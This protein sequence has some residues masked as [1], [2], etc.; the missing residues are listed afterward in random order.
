MKAFL[1]HLGDTFVSGLLAI[2]PVGALFYIL[3]F[4]YRLMDGL[5]GRHTPFGQMVQN[6][7]GRWI[8]GMGI[9][10]MLVLILIVGFITRNFLGRTLQYYMDRLFSSVPG[11]R[12]MYS[13]L[14]QFSNALLNRNTAAFHRVVMFE[15]PKEGINIIG[16]VTNENLGKLNDKTKEESILVY[17]PTAPNP[18]SGMMLLVPK[19]KVTELDIAVEDALSM[20]LSSGSVLPTS[21]ST[22]ETQTSRPRFNPFRW[23]TKKE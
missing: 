2:F 1:R 5:V 22:S 18:L 20:I 11:V 10:M 16:L 13:T 7:L 9:Y 23:H 21:L 6:A 15:Y 17:A 3:W 4:L 19:D 8:P 14:K 12:K